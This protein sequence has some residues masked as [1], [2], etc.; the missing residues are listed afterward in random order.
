LHEPFGSSSLA[1]YL[2]TMLFLR[3]LNEARLLAKELVS[4]VTDYIF[5][6]HW[7]RPSVLNSEHGM[8]GMVCARTG[9]VLVALRA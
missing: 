7:P 4:L 3:R 1:K 9:R 2:P 5:Y 6:D 8:R